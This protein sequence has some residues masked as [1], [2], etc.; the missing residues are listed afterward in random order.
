MR[1]VAA[2]TRRSGKSTTGAALLVGALVLAACG[3]DE[4]AAPAGSAGTMV[5]GMDTDGLVL[6]PSGPALTVD[7]NGVCGMPDQPACPGTPQDA[8]AA[9]EQV[10][11]ASPGGEPSANVRPDDGAAPDDD[12]DDG[13]APV[14]K[15][16]KSGI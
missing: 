8:P 2:T 5:K 15:K 3:S 7:P 6:M 11:A 9:P 1:A 13:D 14:A 16:A 10:Q 12:D 4:G